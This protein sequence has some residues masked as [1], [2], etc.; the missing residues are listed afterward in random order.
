M[1]AAAVLR[2]VESNQALKE[3]VAEIHLQCLTRS[4]SDPTAK[5]DAELDV[6]I[7]TRFGTLIILEV[8]TYDFSG[9]TAKGKDHSAYKKSGPYGKA[10]MVG[11]LIRAMLSQ[12]SNGK[13]LYPHYIDGKIQAQ[14]NTAE[15]NGIRYSYL[16]E[17]GRLLEKELS[18]PAP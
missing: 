7:T 18:V 15:Q 9:D 12:D 16:D 13:E 4:A 14:K 2:A 17:I 8:K 11:P 5:H 6:V 3:A 10:I 1:V